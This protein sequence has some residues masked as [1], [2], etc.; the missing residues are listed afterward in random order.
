MFIF[1]DDVY[2]A[3][4]DVNLGTGT[5]TLLLVVKNKKRQYF[6]VFFSIIVV[7]IIPVV[8]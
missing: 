1:R 6:V 7:T 8:A 2:Y 3:T 4:V 5:G